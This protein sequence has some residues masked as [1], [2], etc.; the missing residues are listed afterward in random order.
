L[1]FGIWN[2]EFGI[3]SLKFLRAKNVGVLMIGVYFHFCKKIL[4]PLSDMQ[5]L[6]LK[7]GSTY[8]QIVELEILYKI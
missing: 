5:I 2:L 4:T 8:T 3:W 7:K 6:V 1:E